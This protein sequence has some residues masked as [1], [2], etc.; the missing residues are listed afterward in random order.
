VSGASSRPVG[1]IPSSVGKYRLIAELGRGGMARVFL[2]MARGPGGF[3]KLFVIKEPWPSVASDPKGLDRFLREAR[4]AA[5]LS[6]P[7]VVQTVE[8]VAEGGGYYIVMEYLDGQ[9]L[10]RVV[11]RAGAGSMA[12]PLGLHLRALSDVLAGLHYAHELCDYEGRPLGLVHRDVSPQN[13]FL[14]YDGQ[15]KLVDF[16]IAKSDGEGTDTTK[17]TIKGK[18]RYM[19]PEQAAG[20]RAD[21]RVDVFSVGVML[22]E[23]LAG[24]RLWGELGEGEV[25]I[26][27]VTKRVPAA[28]EAGAELPPELLRV[29]DRALAVEPDARYQTAG[30]MRADL[31]RAAEA[32]APPETGLGPFVGALFEH[33]RRQVAELIQEHARS[34]AGAPGE[35]LPPSPSRPSA[36]PPPLHRSGSDAPPSAHTDPT[37]VGALEAPGAPAA[38]R[39][40]SHRALG[41]GLGALGVAAFAAALALRP[42]PPPDAEAT[43]APPPA[44]APASPAASAAPDPV[45]ITVRASPA[46]ALLFLDGNPLPSNPHTLRVAADGSRHQVRAEARGYRAKADELSFDRGARLDLALEREARAAPPPAPAP[47]PRKPTR[48]TRHLDVNN[49]Y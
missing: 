37:A 26:H 24:R 27:L 23:A 1:A 33:D 31:E 40:R 39:R 15:V 4:I 44:S 16:G 49:P 6:H 9:P 47:P 36:T 7:N 29:C 35:P 41:I 30:E 21:R 19:A 48:P 3:N 14:T 8:V 43:G 38:P 20:A 46:T 45:E 11:R 12:V 5:R 34:E 28:R 22:W 25:V 10:D 13:V 42:G 18:V 17:G 32:I 2:A